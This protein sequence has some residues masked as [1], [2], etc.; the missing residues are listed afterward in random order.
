MSQRARRAARGPGELEGQED[1]R[2][3]EAGGPEVQRARRA[4]R[5]D[6]EK[7]IPPKAEP[8]E[9]DVCKGWA[10]IKKRAPKTGWKV[11]A[12]ATI[13]RFSSPVPD[14]K[15]GRPGNPEHTRS[16]D[17]KG[18]LVVIRGKQGREGEKN[19]PPSILM[20]FPIG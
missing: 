1:Q 14:P 13:E 5:K 11:E 12:S 17:N 16:V 20:P 18:L 15:V 4:R 3:R 6:R 8:T 19:S 9:T 2:A 7:A 10:H